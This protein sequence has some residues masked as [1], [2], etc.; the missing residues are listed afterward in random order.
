MGDGC[1]IR[2]W[3]DPWLRV[4]VSFR[5]TSPNSCLQHSMRVLDLTDADLGVW[6]EG[7]VRYMF[8]ARDAELI[9]GIP[10][11]PSL[12]AVVRIRHFAPHGCFSVKSAYR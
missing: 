8:N 2:V 5:T 3:G 11:V 6:K 10:L 4:S 12:P 7:M 1:S 9:L